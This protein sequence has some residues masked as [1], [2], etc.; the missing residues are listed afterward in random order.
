MD[1]VTCIPA[2]TNEPVRSYALGSRERG[3]LIKRLAEISAESVAVRLVIGG[4]HQPGRGDR[5]NITMPHRHR[6]VLGTYTNTTHAEGRAAVEAAM[7]A[8]AGWRELPF[9]ERAAILLRAADLAAGPWRETL[10]AAT[11]LGQSKSV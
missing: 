10:S 6:H 9:D 11:M 2:P 5:L 4:T 8:A 3:S 1:A 7:A